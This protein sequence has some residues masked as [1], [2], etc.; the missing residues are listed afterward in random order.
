MALHQ[1]SGQPISTAFQLVWG[2]LYKRY[3]VGAYRNL[4]AARYSEALAW[5]EGWFGDLQTD[6]V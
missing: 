6:P 2:E 4:P 1:R 5:L 3:R